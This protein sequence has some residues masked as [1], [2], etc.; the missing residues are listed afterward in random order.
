MIQRAPIPISKTRRKK[1]VAALQEL[2]EELVKLGDEQL[3]AVDLPETLR[4]AVLEARRI[5]GFEGRRRQLQYIG[6]LMRRVDAAPIRAALDALQAGPRRE[7]ALH[8][9]AEWWRERLLA[10]DAALA[11]FQREYPHADIRSLRTLTGDA[12]RERE[13][14]RAPRYFR[15]LYQALRALLEKR[16]Q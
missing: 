10:D 8:K 9:R 6:K 13:S 5:V 12:A 7:A 16:E 11:D 4:D 1:Q 2:G 14:G 15:E 3:G